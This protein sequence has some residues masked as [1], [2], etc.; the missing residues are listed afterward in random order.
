MA[1]NALNAQWQSLSGRRARQSTGESLSGS[2]CLEIHTYIQG[3]NGRK[4]D[5]CFQVKASD[6][7]NDFDFV[8]SNALFDKQ[9]EFDN[10]YENGND[11]QH[12]HHHHQNEE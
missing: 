6:L 9:K 7:V 3:R 10:I 1:T 2:F 5:E 8:K 4:A 12:H 11:Q